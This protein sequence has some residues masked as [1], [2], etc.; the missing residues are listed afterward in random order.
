MC[1]D[2]C[3]EREGL[4]ARV[5]CKQGLLRDIAQE[6]VGTV[7]TACEKSFRCEAGCGFCRNA[8]FDFAQPHDWH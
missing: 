1:S 4:P 2:Q 5:L 3:A 8:D 7:A 6:H